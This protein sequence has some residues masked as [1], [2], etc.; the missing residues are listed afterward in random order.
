M[1]EEWRFF[2]NDDIQTSIHESLIL[3]LHWLQA[4]SN[5]L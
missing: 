4:G 5:C 1:L 3:E 2:L